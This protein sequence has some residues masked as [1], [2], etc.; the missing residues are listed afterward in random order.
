MRAMLVAAL[1]L[2]IVAPAQAQY[3]PSQDSTLKGLQ[4][5]HVNFAD[6][7]QQLRAG[8]AQQ[9]YESA[10]LEL[11]KAGMRIAADSTEIAPTTDGILN[12]TLFE[13]GGGFSNDVVTLR[14]DV[15]Q[16]AQLSR[17][18]QTMRMVT[19]FYEGQAGGA[20][21]NQLASGVLMKGVNAF[22]NKWLAANGR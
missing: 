11:R 9:L 10:T 21:R 12:I 4:K 18:K 15:E 22:L 5:V 19:W 2:V 16:L 14:I 7:T 6:A 20:D 17:T 8:L 13:Q 3:G 1:S